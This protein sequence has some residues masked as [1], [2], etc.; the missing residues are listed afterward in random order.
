MREPLTLSTSDLTRF[1]DSI[2]VSMAGCWE[3]TGHRNHDGYGIFR[4]NGTVRR[5]AHRISHVIRTG[6]PIPE[7]TEICHRCDN[8]ACVNPDHLF[9]GS[10]SDNMR[11]MHAKRRN[12]HVTKPDRIAKGAIHGGSK[13]TEEQAIDIIR[14]CKAG[15]K[16][17]AVGA[18][19]GIRQGHV[20][21]I[22]NG[23][24]WAHLPR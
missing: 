15:E 11:D 21:R 24:R 17:K 6:L 14:R 12:F 22:V 2:I 7:G 8:R 20:T 23:Q 1:H 19:Y 4:V 16:Q 9:E 3:W 13:L 10:H 5:M 18:I